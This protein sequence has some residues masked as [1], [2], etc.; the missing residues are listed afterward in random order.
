M[1]QFCHDLLI[2]SYRDCCPRRTIAVTKEG[3]K[4]LDVEDVVVGP[5]DLLL[6][7]AIAHGKRQDLRPPHEVL[8][9]AMKQVRGDR[10]K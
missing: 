4:S 9:D 3:V 6:V 1:K 7:L 8:R 5:L 2:N 10:E